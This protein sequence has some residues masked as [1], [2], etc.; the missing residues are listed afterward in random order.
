MATFWS[1]IPIETSFEVVNFGEIAPIRS[2]QDGY[3]TISG[4][5]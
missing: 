2:L 1:K 4:L 3:A 5:L